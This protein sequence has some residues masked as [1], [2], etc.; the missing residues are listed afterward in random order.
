MIKS[1]EI[2]GAEM[3]KYV[4]EYIKDNIINKDKLKT[5]YKI[6]D[7]ILTGTKVSR[8]DYTD[9]FKDLKK[10]YVEE[11]SRF[12]S[13]GDIFIDEEP[14]K[15]IIRHGFTTHSI[16]GETAHHNLYIDLNGMWD[17]R[18]LYTAL[19]RAKYLNQIYLILC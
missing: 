6:E 8:D 3:I 2:T 15:S 1:I 10:Y 17:R 18:M 11:T 12:Y 4:K 5:L 16:Q 7:M 19:S 14:P 9:M 13:K